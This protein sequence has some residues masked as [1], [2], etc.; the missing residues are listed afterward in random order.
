LNSQKNPSR[1]WKNKR[2]KSEGK[3]RNLFPIIDIELFSS[4]KTISKHMERPQDDN[5]K[6]ERTLVNL[7]ENITIQEKDSKYKRS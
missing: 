3:T 1:G 2:P 6:E 7:L 4:E 5:E